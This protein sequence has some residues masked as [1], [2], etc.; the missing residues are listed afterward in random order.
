MTR[1]LLI[2]AL[3]A[4]GCPSSE[5]RDAP[6]FDAAS[7]A[8]FDEGPAPPTTCP[9]GARATTIPET[10]N[11]AKELCDRRFDAVSFP[12]T[13]N[14][15]SNAEDR[16]AAPNQNHGI[17]RQ[18]ADGVRGLMLDTHYYDVESG[19]TLDERLPDVPAIDQA[20]LCH[21]VC[22]LGRRRLL[23]GLCDVTAFL[24]GNRGEV[25][26][27]IFESGI[28]PADTAEVM[29]A[30]GLLEYLY[31]HAGAWPTLRQMIA[32]DKRLVVF[33]ESDGSDPAWY[34]PAWTLIQ[35]TPYS[36]SSAAELSCAPNRGSASS[37]L[38]LVNHWILDPIANPKRAAEI[39]VSSVLLARAQQCQK[40]RGKLPNFVGV[41]FYDIGDLFAAVR[42]LNGL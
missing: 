20:F 7:D 25:L 2:A 27:I 4:M 34:H 14:S 30:A 17:A 6:A 23:E 36:F 31:V 40:E 42:T 32:D 38:F 16:W 10:C 33:T 3:F 35:D 37:P 41:D 28:T 1:P 18:L 19:K 21:G 29:K 5:P 11:G 24:D 12:M 26:S 15:M 13:H 8:A 22:Q 39:N 9:R